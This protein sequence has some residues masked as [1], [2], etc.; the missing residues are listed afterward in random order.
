MK[1]IK[2]TKM[3]QIPD[4]THVPS[5]EQP[6]APTATNYPGAVI[7]VS[8]ELADRLIADGHAVEHAEPPVDEAEP[9]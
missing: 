7:E 3:T 8:D 4:E 1:T 9:Q 6:T 2:L 5:E